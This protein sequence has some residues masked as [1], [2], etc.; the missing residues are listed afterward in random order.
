MYKYDK[1]MAFRITMRKL[2]FLK[3]D[4]Y[5]LLS[6]CTY[7]SVFTG[8]RTS[9]VLDTGFA[10][11]VCVHVMPRGPVKPV[12]FKFARTTVPIIM[13]RANVI[14]R[15]IIVIVCMVSRVRFSIKKN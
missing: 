3:K 4:L 13:D 5:S 15:V 10:L 9:T 1:S 7:F 2:D 11:M 6:S 12:R 8:I 14:E